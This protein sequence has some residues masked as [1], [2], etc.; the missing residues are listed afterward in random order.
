[1]THPTSHLRG[2]ARG[3]PRGFDR[4][5]ALAVALRAFWERGFQA[6]SVAD[7][8][9][10]MGIGIPSLYA[11][12]G[13]KKA[14][15]REVVAV[16]GETY[17][18][19][20]GA[21]VAAG[22]T[23]REGVARALREAA[24]V[25]TAPETPHGCLIISAATNNAAADDDIAEFLRD[26]RRANVTGLRELIRAGVDRGELPAGTDAHALAHHVGAVLQGMSQQARDGA[27]AATLRAV[28]D[29]SMRAW[30]GPAP[31]PAPGPVSPPVR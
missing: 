17:G 7:L 21:A 26:I 31:D 19:F 1:M 2:R 9:A 28:A 6:V 25:Y 11:A 15:F 23:V 18:A 14:L 20:F 22:R 29:L 30:P 3:R 10:A 13:H 27:D 12:F 8:A 16:Y 5:A 4:D 24:D